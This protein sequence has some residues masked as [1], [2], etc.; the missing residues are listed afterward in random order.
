MRE[1]I[2]ITEQEFQFN[3]FFKKHLFIHPTHF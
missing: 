3:D 1:V 2:I